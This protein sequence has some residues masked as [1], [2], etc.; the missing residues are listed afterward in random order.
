MRTERFTTRAQ[1]A[2][3]AAQQLAE[4]EGHAELTNLHLLLSLVD[5]PDG[6]VP[7][8]LERLG[9]EPATIAQQAREQLSRLPRVSGGGTQLTLSNEARRISVARSACGA[10]SRP[11]ALR[12]FDKKASTG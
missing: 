8:V 1:E 9:A 2:I 4:G 5:Q 7:A 12:R 10:G 6:V 11:S 3:V